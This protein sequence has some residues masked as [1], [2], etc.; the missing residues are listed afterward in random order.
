MT[1]EQFREVR[2]MLAAGERH[3]EIAREL[4]LSVWTIVRIATEPRW[5]R[6]DLIEEELLEDDRPADFVSRE[7]RRC[8]GCGAMVYRWPCL[9]CQMAE[10]PVVA[11]AV[12]EEEEE[13]VDEFFEMLQEAAGV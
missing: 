5:Q 9:A 2:R 6:D 11:G 1:L 7:L 13:E 10:L 4:D 12:E 3:V 8:G